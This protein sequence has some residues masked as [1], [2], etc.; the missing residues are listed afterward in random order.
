MGI[1][2]EIRSHNRIMCDNAPVIYFIEEHK[3]FGR[4]VDDFFKFTAE[5]SNVTVFSS[6]ITLSEVLTLPLKEGRTDIVSKYREFLTG[7][8][9]FMLY[10]IDTVIAEKAAE[11]RAH[12]SIKTP[13]AIQLAVGIENSAT[14]FIT[15]DEGLKKVKEIKVVSLSDFL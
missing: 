7:S 9:N 4:I 8:R 11:I 14:L 6:V 15:N 1:T 5:N 10:S 3:T 12:Y 13:D 2:E